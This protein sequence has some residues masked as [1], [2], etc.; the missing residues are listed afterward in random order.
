MPPLGGTPPSA[1]GQP[2]RE[3]CLDDCVQLHL[4]V[5]MRPLPCFALCQV[6]LWAHLLLL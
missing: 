4:G 5:N 1:S 6:V 3:P 2:R